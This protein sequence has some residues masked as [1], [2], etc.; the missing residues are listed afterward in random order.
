MSYC[1]LADINDTLLKKSM[2]QADIDEGTAYVDAVVKGFGVE[3]KLP[4]PYEV[5][6]LAIAYACMRRAL[7]LS[8]KP[9]QGDADAYELKRRAYEKEVKDWQGKLTIELLTGQKQ[10]RKSYFNMTMKRC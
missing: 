2:V 1:E 6:Q 8:G 3:L 10:H 5:K 4:A 9:I 7:Y